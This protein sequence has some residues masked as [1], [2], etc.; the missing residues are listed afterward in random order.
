MKTRT[1]IQ[2]CVL[3]V[4]FTGTS[5]AQRLAVSAAIANVRS[6]P[7]TQYDVLW[8]VEKYFPFNVLKK[9]K[10][11]VYFEDFEGDRGW[12]HESLIGKIPAVVTTIAQGNVRSGP[13]TENKVLYTVER[14]TPFKV[15]G[16][17]GNWLEIE[18]AKGYRGWIYKSLVW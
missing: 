10:S 8:Q 5:W 7:G 13:G 17:K 11:W 18:H 6:G 9:E 2:I 4:L 12:L 1:A 14:G 15:T 3:L 16:K